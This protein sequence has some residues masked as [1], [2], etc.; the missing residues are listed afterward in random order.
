MRYLKE[1]ATGFLTR[2]YSNIFVQTKIHTNMHV[3]LCTYC[4]SLGPQPVGVQ[5]LFTSSLGEFPRHRDWFQYPALLP[6]MVSIA[7]SI[8]LSYLSVFPFTLLHL[9]LDLICFSSLRPTYL[10]PFSGPFTYSL[11]R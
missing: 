6:V 10:Q 9:P 11:L 2:I 4:I 3:Q 7:F 8:R 1:S 5:C